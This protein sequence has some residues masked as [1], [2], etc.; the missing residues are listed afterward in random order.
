MSH[1]PFNK[2]LTAMN[3]RSIWDSSWTLPIVLGFCAALAGFAVG[4]AGDQIR[5]A[6]EVSDEK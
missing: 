2:Y 3:R 1:A 6:W 4:T 5:D